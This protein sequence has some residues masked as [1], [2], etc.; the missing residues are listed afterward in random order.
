MDNTIKTSAN[1]RM[2]V[3]DAWIAAKRAFLDAQ[4]KER[5]LR[6]EVLAL[7]SDRMNDSMAS[8]VENVDTGIG[9]LKV[10]HKLEYKLDADND[11]VDAML[12]KIEKSQEGGNVIA[13]RLVV[14]KP[15]ISVREYK[16][17]APAQKAVVDTILTIK[18]ASKSVELDIK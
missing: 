10:T 17:L 15:E 7:F 16:L 6:A 11:K 14:W 3:L 9:K 2:A 4:T 5:E 1:Y 8:G 13:E 12:D 18:Q